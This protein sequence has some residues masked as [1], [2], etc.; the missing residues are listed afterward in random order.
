MD[1]M[2]VTVFDSER[3]AYDGY[4]AL[5]D[6]DA[7]GIITVY[8]QAVIA[9]DASGKASLK[10]AG[11]GAPVATAVGLAT[12]S[13]IGLLGG[14]VGVAV[15]AAAGTYGGA[16]WDLARTGV[17]ADFVDQVAERLQPGKA[18]VVAEIDEDWVVPVDTRMEA[19]GGVVFRRAR[20]EVV[21]AMVERDVKAMQAELI[22]LQAEYDQATGEAKAKLQARMDATKA[23]LKAAQERVNA[24]TE[25]MDKDVEA[26]LNALE[27]QQA[28]ANAERQ[29]QIQKRIAAVKADHKARSGKL[30]EAWELAREALKP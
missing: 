6:L 11:D 3:K 2:L 12:G 28:K 4:R 14:P 23:E 7:Q 19:A 18:A 5:R 20:G 26:K 30:S 1:K 29:E 22:E 15:G 25:K 13:L 10:E 9:K 8:D 16:I 21:D 27:E 17:S 24:W